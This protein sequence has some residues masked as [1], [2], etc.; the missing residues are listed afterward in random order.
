[1]GPGNA[2]LNTGTI[3]GG[4]D[5]IDLKV[6]TSAITIDQMVAYLG[7]DQALC[8]CGCLEYFRRHGRRQY[9]RPGSSNT[10]NFNLG[11]GT[12]TYDTAYGFSGVNQVNINSGTVVLNGTNSATN[13][14]V[15]GGTLAGTGSIAPAMMTIHTGGT[16]APGTPGVAGTSM[17]INGNLAFQPGAMY[18]VNISPTAASRANV[19]ATLPSM[20]WWKP[21]SRREAT[22]PRLLTTFSTRRASA[23]PSLALRS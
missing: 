18:L 10:V 3:I 22:I 5:A 15:Y 20:E 7:R 2:I 6:A 11:S 4:V 9:R 13:V 21:P 16:F 14:D 8:Q 17:A 12:F 1:M 23:A 19:T